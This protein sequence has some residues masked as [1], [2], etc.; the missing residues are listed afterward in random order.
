MYCNGFHAQWKSSQ[1]N[2][3]QHRIFNEHQ[4]QKSHSHVQNDV[5][6]HSWNVL[7]PQYQNFASGFDD[8]K[9]AFG[10][11][12]AHQSCRFFY[13]KFFCIEMLPDFGLSKLSDDSQG[14]NN[15]VLNP[16]S[17]NANI[18]IGSIPYQGRL[19][20]HIL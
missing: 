20:V 1:L 10:P 12:F 5:G 15:G 2:S 17:P 14:S 19:Y 16:T 7:S 8:Q 13:C 18:A 9:L 6:Y 4:R 3:Q 11:K